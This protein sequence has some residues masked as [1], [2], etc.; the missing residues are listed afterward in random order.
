MLSTEIL[1]A[2]VSVLFCGGGGWGGNGERIREYILLQDQ[3]PEGPERRIDLDF[4]LQ[5]FSW[6]Q[7]ARRNARLR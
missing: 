5:R 3:K 4:G 2:Y 6:G 7:P 1:G